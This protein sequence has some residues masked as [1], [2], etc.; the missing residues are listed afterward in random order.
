MQQSFARLPAT[1]FDA[2]PEPGSG[3]GGINMTFRKHYKYIN[4]LK[5]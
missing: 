1:E 3:S 5:L 4:D 2:A